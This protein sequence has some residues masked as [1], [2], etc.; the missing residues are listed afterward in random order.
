MS[1]LLQ[2]RR[3]DNR[4]RQTLQQTVVARPAKARGDPSTR[5]PGLHRSSG[6]G[7]IERS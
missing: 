1:N 7:G 6:S 3:M 5:E 2:S 4:D